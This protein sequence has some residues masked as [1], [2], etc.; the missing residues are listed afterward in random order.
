MA[1][2]QSIKVTKGVKTLEIDNPT[3][4]PLIE[5][6]AQGAVFKLSEEKCVKIYTNPLQ[7]QMELEA[8]KAGQHLTFF[9]RLYEFG[10]NYIV[11]D[12]FNAP[13]LKEYL[14]Y[15]GIHYKKPFVYFKRNEPCKIHDGRCPAKTYLCFGE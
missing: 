15:S 4:Y 10:E 13:T 8:L 1:D 14:V 12:Y 2:F 6:G 9:P 11:M 7:A 5:M 3:G